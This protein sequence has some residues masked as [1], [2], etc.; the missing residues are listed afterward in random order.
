MTKETTTTTKILNLIFLITVLLCG[1]FII[2]SFA[3][4]TSSDYIYV[5]SIGH[6]WSKGTIS[7]VQADG[8]ICSG[9]KR[10]IIDQKWEGTQ[11]G[12]FCNGIYDTLKIG[13]CSDTNNLHKNTYNIQFCKTVYSIPPKKINI[14]KN[15]NLCG[16]IG[17]NYLELKTAN[18][19]NSQHGSSDT[20][21]TTSDT[22]PTNA[23]TT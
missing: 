3:K 6:N 16:K 18:D 5:S 12:C 2:I 10:S 15:V 17:P 8:T 21:S 9:D 11:T 20:T 22:V 4:Y 13:M 14:W 23:A 19:P 7:D 1:I